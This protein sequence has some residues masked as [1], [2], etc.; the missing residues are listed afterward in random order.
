MAVLLLVLSLVHET[1]GEK[2][3]VL[4]CIS[5]IRIATGAL[6]SCSVVK[7][8]KEIINVTAFSETFDEVVRCSIRRPTKIIQALTQ[9]VSFVAEDKEDRNRRIPK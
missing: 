5:R 7:Q 3:G 1:H 2:W 8:K 9:T 4:L 6:L